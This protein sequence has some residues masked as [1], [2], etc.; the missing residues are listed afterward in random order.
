[1]TAP[2]AFP[3][4][5]GVLDPQP[6]AAPALASLLGVIAQFLFFHEPLGLNALLVTAVFLAAAW[7]LRD[8]AVSFRAQDAWLPAGAL[9]FASCCAVRADAPLLAF[10]ALTAVGFGAATVV[11][12]SGVSFSALPG[13]GLVAGGW[14]GRGSAV[15]GGA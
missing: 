7:A 10:D 14:G 6:P 9:A 12:W 1:M 15:L 3:P 11:A 8:R 2:R 4:V 13:V 5:P